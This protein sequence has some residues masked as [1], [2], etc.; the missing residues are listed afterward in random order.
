[1]G[2]RRLCLS[3]QGPTII[4]ARRIPHHEHQERAALVSCHFQ[5][6]FI[7]TKN[8]LKRLTRKVILTRKKCITRKI[9]KKTIM[10]ETKRQHIQRSRSTHYQE[11]SCGEVASENHQSNQL[12]RHSRLRIISCRRL[13][14]LGAS[15][16]SINSTR[17]DKPTKNTFRR[18]NCRAIAT[19]NSKRHSTS[20]L[21]IAIE[22]MRQLP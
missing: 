1:M 2:P 7:S 12:H 20:E 17:R 22:R 19:M 5:K 11:F 9:Y 13:C 6:T 3:A 16:V 14:S 10:L 18:K 4:L 21:T 8:F 15:K